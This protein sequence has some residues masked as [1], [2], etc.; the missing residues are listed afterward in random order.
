MTRLVQKVQPVSLTANV[1]VKL[2]MLEL[3][4]IDVNIAFIV[5]HLTKNAQVFDLL[6]IRFAFILSFVEFVE[7]LN[8]ERGVPTF[9]ADVI[10]ILKQHLIG[11]KCTYIYHIYK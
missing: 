11:A 3:S 1:R 4:A 2:V 8:Q 5:H 9:M 7:N 10:G 6:I